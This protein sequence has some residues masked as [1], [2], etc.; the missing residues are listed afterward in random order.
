MA[1]SKDDVA[2]FS[3]FTV[4]KTEAPAKP[5][6]EPKAETPAAPEAP[7]APQ[8]A[9][10]EAGSSPSRITISPI[11]RVCADGIVYTAQI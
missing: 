8:A 11:A 5:A 9:K 3:D 6:A 7:A 1:E 10:T 2:S 4:S